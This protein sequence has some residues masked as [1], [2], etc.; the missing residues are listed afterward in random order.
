MATVINN[1]ATTE[2]DSSAVGVIVGVILGILLII[3]FFVYGL[4]AL[5]STPASTS[6]DTSNI[7]LKV[8]VPGSTATPSDGTTNPPATTPTNP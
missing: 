4:P 8:D 6:Q 5:R 7:N 2:S 3:L 1:P